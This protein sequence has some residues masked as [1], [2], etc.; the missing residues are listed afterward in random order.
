MTTRWRRALRAGVL[1]GLV[2]ALV[3]FGR[4]V[5]WRSA[6]LVV[7][8]ADPL[9]MA[10]ALTLNLLSL[11]LKGV[12]WW[13]FL[14][15]L[16]SVRLPLVL[17]ATF[18]GAS[19]NNLVVAQGGEGARVLLVSRAAG[20]SSAG[21]LAALALERT[22]D[23]VSYLALL[24]TA[25]WM[26]DLPEHIAHWRGA[27][28]AALA[29]ATALLV[30]LGL[31]A[32]RRAPVA[33]HTPATTGGRLSGY[34]GRMRSGTAMVA[35]P[36]RLAAALVLSLLA[37]SL[38]VAT[39]HLTAR[40]AHLPLPL[41]GSVAAMLAVGISFLVRATPGNVGVFQVIYAF[42][43]RSFGIAEA[44]AI[45]VALLIQTLQVIPTIVLGTLVAPRLLAGTSRHE[46]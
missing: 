33:D 9:L 31:A 22:L 18:A 7:R 36:P 40:A 25:A 27:A 20:V 28:A 11:A 16:G 38:Q 37:W 34:L 35:T 17:R 12:R 4:R 43:V 13:V 21:V 32:R 5:D 23:A 3:V 8:A 19:L 46:S 30:A 24:V 6:A 1:L 42:T 44:P 14:R 10:G 15:P 29:V 39:Y 2:A 26:L 45:A 41:A